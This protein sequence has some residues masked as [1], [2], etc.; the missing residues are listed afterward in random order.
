MKNILIK[1][2]Y[3]LTLLTVINGCSSLVDDS[4]ED[5]DLL[6]S[7]NAK[8]YFQGILLANQFF[9]NSD[10]SRTSM[11]WLNQAN[12]EDRQ[13]AVLNNW[14]S[15]AASEF[16]DDWN[17]AYANCITQA[18]IAE[19]L[20][21][22]ESNKMLKGAI[23]VIDANCIGTITALWGDA[24]YS[25][26]DI[27]GKN[28]TPKFDSQISLYN[29]VQLLLDDAIANLNSPGVIPASDFYYNGDAGSWIKLAYSLKARYYLHTKDYVNAKKNA[30]LGISDASGDFK[31]KF[32]ST[33]SI[34]DFN[35]FYTFLIYERDSYMS[36]DSYASRLLNPSDALYR[37][38][39]KTDESARFAYTYTDLSEDGYFS[40]SL[41]VRGADYGGT[42]GK[43][44]NDTAAPLVTYGEMLLIIAEVDARDSFDSGLTSYNNYRALLNTGYSIGINNDGYDSE[45]FKYEAYDSSDFA[46][47]GIEN[48]SPSITEQDALLREI[49]QERYTYFIGHFESFNDFGRTNN[50]AEIQLKTGYTGTPQ[51]FLYPQDEVNANPNTP[52]P[53]PTVIT[54][55]PVHN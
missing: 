17:L 33:G 19:E 9:Q 8:D 31:A 32:G 6:I 47:G 35:P 26:I 49:L 29:K 52:S 22:K 40:T 25:D 20:C 11:I 42:N 30:L 54:K 28:L 27:T 13:Y 10:G 1:L 18:K 39:E 15:S 50:K 55:T 37:G 48:L 5:P 16:N 2:I 24:P 34:Q 7:A 44:G 41:N 45:T 43:F 38:N 53:I 4:N 36:G 46:S 21:D 14:N 12:G 3:C 51:R 23:Q